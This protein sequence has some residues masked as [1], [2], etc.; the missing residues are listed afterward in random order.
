MEA[1]NEP[2]SDLPSSPHGPRALRV[3]T[4]GLVAAVVAF[5]VVVGFLSVEAVRRPDVGAS[6]YGK[7][8]FYTGEGAGAYWGPFAVYTAIGLAGIVALFWRVR[9]R[10]RR[11]ERIGPPEGAIRSRRPA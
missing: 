6:L 9:T 11:G 7:G 10:L 8:R 2:S 4:V 3:V 5:V 1:P